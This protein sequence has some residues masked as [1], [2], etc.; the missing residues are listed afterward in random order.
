MKG[1]VLSV[2]S[3]PVL[4]GRLVWVGSGEGRGGGGGA[5]LS[6]WS[7]A[8]KGPQS[9]ILFLDVVLNGHHSQARGRQDLDAGGNGE[10]GV[11]QQG[12]WEGCA[13]RTGLSQPEGPVT[14]KRACHNKKGLSRHE[15][16]GPAC[17]PRPLRLSIR[18]GQHSRRRAQSQGR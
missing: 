5:A 2:R 6:L 14:R 15:S 9:V 18:G 11:L 8:P 10:A 13:L 7:E 1:R 12:K 16:L 4:R 3:A 17:R